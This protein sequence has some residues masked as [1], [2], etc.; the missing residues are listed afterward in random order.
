MPTLSPAPSLTLSPV[1]TTSGNLIHRPFAGGLLRAEEETVAAPS[2]TSIDFE[3]QGSGTWTAVIPEGTTF[4]P[5]D[6]ADSTSVMKLLIDY[7]PSDFYHGLANGTISV[8]FVAPPA[9][10]TQEFGLRRQLELEF[11]N[12]LGVPI[13]GFRYY[14][15]NKDIAV[16]PHVGSIH[17]TD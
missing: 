8:E 10:D 2:T 9:P 12:D 13:T 3:I 16:A 17:P 11:K 15:A 7:T 14:L 5:P 6:S 1:S 4:V